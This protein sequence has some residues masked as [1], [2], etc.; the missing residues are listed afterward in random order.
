[1]TM[2]RCACAVTLHV[3]P[4]GKGEQN[5]LIQVKMCSEIWMTP[6]YSQIYDRVS[7]FFFL[8]LS[9][10]LGLFSEGKAKIAPIVVSD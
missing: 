8:P 10:P 4:A 2:T 1:M 3:A 6:L 7:S 9:I 5:C